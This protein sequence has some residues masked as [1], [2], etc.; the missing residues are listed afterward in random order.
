[1]VFTFIKYEVPKAKIAATISKN[2]LHS[3][4][5][6]VTQAINAANKTTNIVGVSA[7]A[8]I[9]FAAPVNHGLRIVI[10]QFS[11]GWFS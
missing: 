5:L 2:G 4:R 8:V 7:I 3:S 10:I 9:S 1:M 6:A 11:I